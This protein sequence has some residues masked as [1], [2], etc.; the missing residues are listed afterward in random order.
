MNLHT[1]ALA[2]SG[3]TGADLA[4]LVNEAAILAARENRPAVT[5]EDMDEAMMKILTGPEK[6]SRVQREQDRRDTAFH[7]AGHAVAMYRLPTHDP[8]HQISIIPRGKALGVTISL[9]E[10][11]TVSLT[12]NQMFEQIVALLG[13][14]VAEDLFLGDI[15]TGASNDLQRAT[16]LAHDMVATYGMSER[17]GAVA[18]HTDDEVFVGGSYGK[19]RSYSEQTAGEMDEEIKSTIDRAYAK[20]REI[21]EADQEKL[22]QVAEFLLKYDTMSGGQFRACMEGEAIPEESASI[23]SQAAEKE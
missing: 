13:G 20:C 16:Q 14:R 10:H 8:V 9:P 2:T 1:V 11:D 15:S 19:T 4:N 22:R 21:L 12:R 17:L 5:M 23:L 3:F 6:K 7:E 18:F